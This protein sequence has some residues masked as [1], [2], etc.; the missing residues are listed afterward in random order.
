MAPPFAAPPCI[1]LVF[2]V[3]AAAPVPS[4]RHPAT[5]TIGIK[6]LAFGPSPPGIRVGDTVEW[7]NEDILL[8]SV[9]ARDKGF[10]VDVAAGA[11]AMVAMNKAGVI[12]YFCKYHPGMTGQLTVAK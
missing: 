4:I 6:D 11:K 8:H 7:T 9:T 3:T 5:F 1:A 2:L 12:A 10:D